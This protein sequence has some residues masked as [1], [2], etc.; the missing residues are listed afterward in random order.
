MWTSCCSIYAV[1]PGTPS[2]DAMRLLA[3]WAATQD[4]EAADASTRNVDDRASPMT[5]GRRL[6]ERRPIVWVPP[7]LG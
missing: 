7:R 1:E 6:V 2:H 5:A 4:A 3:T